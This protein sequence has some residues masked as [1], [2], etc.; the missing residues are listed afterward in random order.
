VQCSDPSKDNK[1]ARSGV[2]VAALVWPGALLEIEVI[3]AKP[4]KTKH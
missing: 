4:H 1:P 2:Q 3:A